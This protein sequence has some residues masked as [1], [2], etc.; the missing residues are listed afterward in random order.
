MRVKL[1][2]GVLGTPIDGWAEKNRII[3]EK[4]YEDAMNRGGVI[5]GEHGIGLVKKDFLPRNIGDTAIN[6]MKSIKHAMDPQG[7][8]NP[9]KI[10]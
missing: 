9:G 5:S 8:L 3:E 7:I 6:V 10:F 1:E 4:L 2:D